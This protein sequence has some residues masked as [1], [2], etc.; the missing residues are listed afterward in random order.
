M[1]ITAKLVGNLITTAGADR[2][3]TI[4]LH[5]AQIQGFFDIPV[6]HLLAEPVFLEYFKTLDVKDPV[7]VS[8]D[9]GNVKRSRSYAEQLGAELAIIDKRRIS[10]TEATRPDA[11]SGRSRAATCSWSTT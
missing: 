5:A 10:G 4:D 6:D 11:S 2:V 9:V 3:L 1:P 8:P 7:F